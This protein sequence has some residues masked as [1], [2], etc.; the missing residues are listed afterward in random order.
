MLLDSGESGE[1]TQGILPLSRLEVDEATST[2]NPHFLLERPAAE[3]AL[4]FGRRIS[5]GV[6]AQA[7]AQLSQKS[8][9]L[10]A[11]GDA[12][13]E[14]DIEAVAQGGASGDGDDAGL[15]GRQNRPE[16][17]KSTRLNSS[18]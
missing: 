18:H 6:A 9:D 16:D 1:A 17:R 14:T 5:Q 12:M 10:P 8:R 7:R 2:G 3:G 4:R 11:L 13:V 15:P